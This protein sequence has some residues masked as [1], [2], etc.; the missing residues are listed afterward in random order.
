MDSR[1]HENDKLRGKGLVISAEIFLQTSTLTP[2]MPAK[3]GIHSYFANGRKDEPRIT[4]IFA[5]L[6]QVIIGFSRWLDPSWEIYFP[7]TAANWVVCHE[8]KREGTRRTRPI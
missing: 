6:D 4:R 1:L 7:A 5:N 3:A 8:L 2:V